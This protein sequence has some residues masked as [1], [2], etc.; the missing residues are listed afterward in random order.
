MARKRDPKVKII[1]N[2]YVGPIIWMKGFDIL[3]I[4]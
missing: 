1:S 4:V 3:N 2:L